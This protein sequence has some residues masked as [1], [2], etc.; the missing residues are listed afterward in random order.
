MKNPRIVLAAALALCGASVIRA[1]TP[2]PQGT[3]PSV[4]S[5]PA[6][7]AVDPLSL[8][9]AGPAYYPGSDMPYGP[10]TVAIGDNVNPNVPRLWL[11]LN[12]AL[13]HIS[14]SP[15]TS[16]LITT[17]ANPADM[18]ILGAPSTTVLIGQNHYDY[19]WASGVEFRSGGWWNDERTFGADGST[20]WNEQRS[21]TQFIASDGSIGSTPLWRPIYD[22]VAQTETSVPVALPGV[23]AGD[24]LLYEKMNYVNGDSNLMLNVYRDEMRSWTLLLGYRLIFLDEHL[25]MTQDETGLVDNAISY[26]GIPLPAGNVLQ[27]QDVIE[28]ENRYYLGQIGARW[29]RQMGAFNLGVT[30][31]FAFGW[32]DE[33]TFYSGTTTL[34]PPATPVPGGLLVQ[35]SQPYRNQNEQFVVAPDLSVVGSVRLLRRLRLD[36]EYHCTF[37]SGAARAGEMID[38]TVELNQAPSSATYNGILGVNPTYRPQSVSFF[39][40][41]FSAGLTWE[42]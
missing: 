24:F 32:A 11:T 42:Y 34:N 31:K 15:I 2:P 26:L 35:L 23:L 27:I 25:Y 39:A 19:D 41:T 40:Q 36:A 3:T 18:G 28:T 17:S 14:S 13:T 22:P 21:I 12:W 8:V 33:R 20:T 4:D 37:I 9:P 5:P 7:S 6:R 10:S 16:P 38:R 29:E 30:Y 1:Q